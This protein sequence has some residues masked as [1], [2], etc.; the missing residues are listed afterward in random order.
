MQDLTQGSIHGHIGKL[1]GFMLFGMLFQSLYFL[2][3]LYFVARVGSF[4]VAAVSLAGQLMMVTIGLTQALTVGTTT[5]VAHA[6]GAKDPVRARFVFNQAQVLATLAGL[7]FVAVT[8]VLR[9]RFA[10]SLAADA[11]TIQA[12]LDYLDWYLPA[13]G[14]QFLL[15]AMSAALRGAGEVKAP[16]LVGVLSVL[17]NTVL[18]PVLIAGWGTGV[19]LGV[20]GAGLASFI[21]IVVAAAM[22][23]LWV[24]KYH[25]VLQLDPPSWRPDFA[26]WRRLLAIGLPAGGELILIAVYSTVIYAIVRDFGADAQAGVGAGMRVMQACFIPVL[27]VAFSIAPIAAQSFGA[28]RFD[29]VRETFRAGLVWA[30]GLMGVLM[31]VCHFVPE[32]LVAPFTRSPEAL[33]VGAGML[34]I[35]AFNFIASGVVFV[36]GSIFQAL[37]NTLPSLLASAS[38]LLVFVV[39]AVFIARLPWFRLPHLWWL[40]VGTLLI[41]MAGSLWLLRREMRRKLPADEPDAAPAPA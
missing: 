21:A 11:A 26:L 14:V 19:P 10:A 12:L 33:A 34:S 38:R 27:A 32:V 36:A 15:V 6:L 3:D 9:D 23:L 1:A 40:S 20:A 7:A 41:Q 22:L 39:P 8:F 25:D 29:R 17:L 31:L 13:M 24:R 16:M 18:A 28:Q 4:A 5:L 35:I 30:C 37:G 2:V